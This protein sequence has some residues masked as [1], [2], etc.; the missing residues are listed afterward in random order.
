MMA[1]YVNYESMGNEEELESTGFTVSGN[2]NAKG[3][4]GLVEN[5]TLRTNGVDG[6]IVAKCK[7]DANA[8]LYHVRISSDG[9]NWQWMGASRTTAVKVFNC[10]V[11]VSLQVQ[12]RCENRHGVSPWSSPVL[13]MIG[14]TGTITSMHI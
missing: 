13:A 11:G 1:S 2:S 7:R 9:V 8:D 10:P 14:A 3:L 6:L 5:V 12:M 4:V